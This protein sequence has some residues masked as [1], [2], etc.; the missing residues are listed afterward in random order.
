[1]SGADDQAITPELALVDPALVEARRQAPDRKVTMSSTPPSNGTFFIDPGQTAPPPSPA[2]A[3]ISP[4]DPVP[5]PELIPA[6]APPV[7][8][9]PGA[10]TQASMRDVPLGTLIFRAGLLAEEQ[11]EDALQ[12]GMRTGKRLGEVL[13]ERGWLQERDL[14]RLLAGQKGL[15]FVELSGTFPEPAA[16]QALPEEKARLQ[17]VLPLRV[18]DGRLVVA[19]ADPSNELV[20]EN[21]RRTLGY[22]PQLVVAA[23]GDLSRAIGEAYADPVALALVGAAPAIAVQEP[24]GPAPAPPAPAEAAQP[25]VEPA[26]H[27][28]PVLYVEPTVQ[29]APAVQVEA[30]PI[31]VE[32]LA[33]GVEPPS[34]IV[35]PLP[36]VL[37]PAESRTPQPAPAE[38]LIPVEPPVQA[39]LSAMPPTVEQ[40]PPLAPPGPVEATAA[41]SLPTQPAMQSPEPV[42]PA[43]L[44]PPTTVAEPPAFAE[45][46]ALDP[47]PAPAPTPAPPQ[48]QPVTEP[49]PMVEQLPASP[50][51]HV[52]GES[53]PEH[54]ADA[55]YAVVLRLSDGEHLEIG[56]FGSAEEA[57]ARAQEVVSHIAATEGTTSW[58]FFAGRFLRPDT[59]VSVDLHEDSAD[60]WM[61]SAA[62]SRWATES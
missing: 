1:L 47:Q 6:P 30:A 17:G 38:Q 2:A 3:P 19:V 29:V 51:E 59:I 31:A 22:D 14:G 32:P 53:E 10:G 45:P 33:P 48:T 41:P 49:P 21:L 13:L 20:L 61:G 57:Q 37:P 62:R 24:L 15:S 34:L 46:V 35:Q 27:V 28:E 39:P 7:L 43:P 8:A 60:R 16:L 54:A 50:N 55:T 58:P 12:E 40:L 23:Y 36:T 9:E 18:E 42:V 56:I 5:A 26:P 52:P 44:L 25:Q 11:L 4:P